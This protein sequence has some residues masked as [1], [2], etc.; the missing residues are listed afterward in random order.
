MKTKLL[1]LI[2]ITGTFALFSQNDSIKKSNIF[3]TSGRVI[4]NSILTIPSDFGFMGKQISNDWKKTGIYTAGILGLIATDKITTGFWQ[5]H[6]ELN[7]QY[8]L[9]SFSPV[10]PTSSHKWMQGN[11]AYLTFPTI[12]IYLGAFISN[13]ERGQYTAINTLKAIQ[14]SWIISHIGLKTIFGRNRPNRPLSEPAQYPWT[15]NNWDFFN[16]RK[17]FLF[18]S[19][20]GSALPSLHSTTYFAIAKVYQMEFNNY[21]IPYGVIAAVW[22][23]DIEGHNHWVSDI[24]VAGIVGTIIGKSIVL[25]SW[26][27]RGINGY[28]KKNKDISFQVI[29]Q[30]SS[31]FSGLHIVGNF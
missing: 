19:S 8:S 2:F 11:N 7:V 6:V 25:S 26:K 16:K 9:P 29:P 5:E 17:E 10:N 23:S 15:N 18:A 3:Q 20:E 27:K 1:L 31:E 12:G 28:K 13:N 21:W 30:F 22:L 4:K 24:V 14:Y